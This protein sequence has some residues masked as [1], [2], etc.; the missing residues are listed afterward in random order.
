MVP[1]NGVILGAQLL[2]LLLLL[3]LLLLGRLAAENPVGDIPQELPN[4]AC[5]PSHQFTG[6]LPAA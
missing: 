1:E 3:L 5:Q 6:Q 4:W 2:G